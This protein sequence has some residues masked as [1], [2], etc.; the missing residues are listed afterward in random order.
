MPLLPNSTFLDF[1]SYSTTTATTVA[2][3]YGLSG[4]PIH[5]AAA[6]INV[7]FVL[8]RANDPTALLASNWGTRQAALEQLNDS[9]TLWSMQAR[10]PPTTPI[11]RTPWP[12]TAPCSA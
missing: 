7:A 11:P 3:A 5:A 1:T 6:S 8:P 12:D 2:D 9:G 4:P 10:P